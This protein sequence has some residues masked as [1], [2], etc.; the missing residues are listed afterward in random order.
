MSTGIVFTNTDFDDYIGDGSFETP[1]NPFFPW[2]SLSVTAA[3]RFGS[4]VPVYPN[5]NNNKDLFSSLNYFDMDL[6]RVIVQK[7]LQ[8]PNIGDSTIY[9]FANDGTFT[10]SDANNAKGVVSL[11]DYMNAMFLPLPTVTVTLDWYLTIPPRFDIDRFM[12]HS[13]SAVWGLPLNP[14][15]IRVLQPGKPIPLPGGQWMSIFPTIPPLGYC[16]VA[17]YCFFQEIII[18]GAHIENQG[19][20]TLLFLQNSS[21]FAIAPKSLLPT[22]VLNGT[23]YRQTNIQQR[24]SQPSTDEKSKIE[25]TYSYTTLGQLWFKSGTTSISE[26]YS[27][28]LPYAINIQLLSG[29][30]D[31]P[32]GVRKLFTNLIAA[33]RYMGAWFEI[34][35]FT[36][37]W[38]NPL[39]HPTLMTESFSTPTKYPT[40]LPF[41]LQDIFLACTDQLIYTDLLW[42]YAEFPPLPA[43]VKNDM[44]FSEAVARAGGWSF[45]YS[46]GADC[47]TLT[48]AY[49]IENGPHWN[50][51]TCSCYNTGALI[52][53]LGLE[54][55][56][57][58]GIAGLITSLET[59]IACFYVQ[60]SNNKNSLKNSAQPRPDKDNCP[61]LVNCII[62]NVDVNAD[63]AFLVNN[64]TDNPSTAF[65]DY[66]LVLIIVGVIA[67][68]VL[69]MI[70][71]IVLV[72][73]RSRSRK[74][75]ETRIV[76][77]QNTGSRPQD[78]DSDYDYSEDDSDLEEFADREHEGTEFRKR[79]R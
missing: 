7:T 79:R 2:L 40:I 63:T 70:I 16:S 54:G 68:V 53:G 3:A 44:P 5:F 51:T 15:V 28:H 59:N 49:C 74:Q 36:G 60:C 17:P 37:S 77:E 8:I 55:K 57:G 21:R 72:T 41:G 31:S 9:P 67:A 65:S 19:P 23:T 66:S 58:A 34:T 69:V 33:S 25:P 43:S 6:W 78:I 75:A 50:S 12:T 32:D 52:R 27:L 45:N 20:Q 22:E 11:L 38:M 14:L 64:C 30:A 47:D 26:A 24:I 56:R 39:Y 73:S 4:G 42:N 61:D 13:Y 29:F 18:S 48:R 62:D 46:P 71:I 1:A 35:P 10:S 76:I